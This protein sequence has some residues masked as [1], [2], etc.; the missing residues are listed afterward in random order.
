MQEGG[1]RRKYI[2]VNLPREWGKHLKEI[3]SDPKMKAKIE[4][5]H[6]TTTNSGIGKWIIYEYLVENTSFRFK[7]INTYQNKITIKDRRSGRIFDIFVKD[8]NHLFCEDCEV[9]DC[10]HIDFVLTINEVKK[11]LER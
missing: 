1:E 6:Y 9:G 10:E 4:S 3:L 5:R 7:H 11:A 2:D 8:K